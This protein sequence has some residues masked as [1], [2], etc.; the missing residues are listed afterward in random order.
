MARLVK[1]FGNR[2]RERCETS[3]TSVV[4]IDRIISNV[5]FGHAFQAERRKKLALA[6]QMAQQSGLL[7]SVEHFTAE[8]LEHLHRQAEFFA[9]LII[10]EFKPPGLLVPK[11]L[12]QCVFQLFCSLSQVR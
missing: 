10:L 2:R 8:E 12:L 7:L 3:A 5:R 6:G 1:S 9:C 4:I 11:S